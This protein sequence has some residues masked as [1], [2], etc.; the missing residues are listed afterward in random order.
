MRIKGK[1]REEKRRTDGGSRDL[2]SRRERLAR[3]LVTEFLDGLLGRASDTD[4]GRPVGSLRR[5]SV[6]A[7]PVS[8][9]EFVGEGIVLFLPDE[10]RRH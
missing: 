3:L 8:Q 7:R 9:R 5:R 6:P 1:A 10:A 2:L 4:A